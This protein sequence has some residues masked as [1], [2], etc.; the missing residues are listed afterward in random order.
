MFDDLRDLYQDAIMQR[1]RAPQHGRKLA[2][3]DADAKGDNPM[4]GDRVHVFL[5]HA[6]GVVAEA[7]FEARGCAI[8]IASADLMAEAVAGQSDERAAEIAAA[9]RQMMQTGELADPSLE[10]L[11]PLAAVSEAKSRIKCVT[12]PWGALESALAS[13][14]RGSAQA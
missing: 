12:L 11:R 2:V 7:G 4:C 1:G 13:A 5:R 8:S 3:F 10:I 9:V 14:P 6:G